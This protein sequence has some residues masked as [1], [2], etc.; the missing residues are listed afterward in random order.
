DQGEKR[1]LALEVMHV[2]QP[3]RA[4]I[5]FGKIESMESAIQTGKRDGM[6]A[7]DDDLIR[8]AMTGKITMETARRFAKDPDAIGQRSQ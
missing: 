6:R 2:N 4:A 3:V 1:V 8:L 7:L 5:K